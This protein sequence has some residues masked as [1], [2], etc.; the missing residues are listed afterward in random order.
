V[1]AAAVAGLE[2]VLFEWAGLRLAVPAA[3][4][5]A[6]RAQR[7]ATS[8]SIAAL[9]GLEPEIANGCAAP[10]APSPDPAPG[11]DPVART[12]AAERLLEV[13]TSD[14]RRFCFRVQEP[15]Q[16]RFFAANA[17]RPLPASLAACSRASA[18]QALAREPLISAQHPDEEASFR[19]IPVLDVRRLARPE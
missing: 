4:V 2:L 9:L 8:P 17:L 5:R 11:P 6:L 15:V 3:Q 13:E 19:L 16:T 18:V 7:D 1:S 12:P 14:R 10:H